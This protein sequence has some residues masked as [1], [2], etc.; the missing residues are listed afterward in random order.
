MDLLRDTWTN[1]RAHTLRFSLTSLSIVW[2]AFLLTFLNGSL[3]G[4]DAH[5]KREIQDAGPKLV[6]MWPGTRIESRVGERDA[7]PVALDN[8]DLPRIASLHGVEGA[9]PNLTAWSQIVRAEGRTKLFSVNGI[10]VPAA[11]IRNLVPEHGR[12]LS[13]LDVERGARVAYLG[14]V[15]AERLFGGRSPLGRTL[16]IDS[17]RF[18]V[19]GVN[20]AKG[21]QMVSVG[22][23]DDWSIFIPYTTAQR[24]LLKHER[25]ERA[26]FAPL[27]REESPAAIRAVREVIGLHH[28]FPPD[29]DS[30]LAFFNVHDSLQLLH[31]IMFGFRVFLTAAGIITLLVGAVGVMNIMLVVVG[32]RTDE[33]G[34]RKAVGATDRAIF[35]QFLAE[36][37]AVCG[38]SGVLGTVLGVGLSQLVSRL[39]PAG[40]PLGSAPSLSAPM[41]LGIAVAL[42]FVGVVA[43]VLPAVRASRVPPADALRAA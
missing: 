24:W 29:Q 7:R 28:E 30:A 40:G 32:E 20:Q 22:G 17:L 35:R 21:E 31:A 8:D 43:G 5:Y 41:V 36:A 2:G 27:T 33:I 6:V 15:A 9:S 1:L 14:A 16:Q 26:V 12:F 18:R 38:I 11:S 10:D 13:E 39:A 4:L 37:A 19:I 34:L 25:L 3:R 42:V 23:W